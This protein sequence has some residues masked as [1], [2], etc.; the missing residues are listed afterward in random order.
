MSACAAV[1][2]RCALRKY[3]NKKEVTAGTAARAAIAEI[4]PAGTLVQTRKNIFF[5]HWR[6]P[7][8]PSNFRISR[9]R[10]GTAALTLTMS[11]VS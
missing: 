10:P 1:L 11:H 2:D 4:V 7:A 6:R 8:A 5:C 3:L 9:I